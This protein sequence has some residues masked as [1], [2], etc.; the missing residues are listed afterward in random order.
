MDLPLLRLVDSERESGGVAV[1]VLGAGEI[2]NLRSEGLDR[3]EAGELGPT[4]AARQSPSL[5][6]SRYRT[7][8]GARS[9]NVDVARYTQQAVLTANIEEARYRVLMAP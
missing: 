9:L 4:V 5:V 1:E 6:A 7:G 2:K 8:G 3:T